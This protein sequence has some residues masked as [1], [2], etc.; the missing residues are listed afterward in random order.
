M[1]KVIKAANYQPELSSKYFDLV[2]TS[3][4]SLYNQPWSGYSVVSKGKAKE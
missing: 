2:K 3:G 1:K 4:M